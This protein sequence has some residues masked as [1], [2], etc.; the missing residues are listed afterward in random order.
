M[1]GRFIVDFIC[2]AISIVLEIDG[3]IHRSQTLE[4]QARAT[5]L[6]NQGLKVLRFS[7]QEVLTDM[8]G[9]LKR[10]EVELKK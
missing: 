4:D 7:N 10:L 1:V 6:E 9:V 5:V 3:P 8:E 2:T